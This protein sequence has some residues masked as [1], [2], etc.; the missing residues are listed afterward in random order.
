MGIVNVT[1][2]SFSRDGCF[3]GSKGFRRALALARRHVREGADIIDIGGE[4]TRPGARR[5]PAREE[6]ARVIPPVRALAKSVKVPISVDTY[7]PVVAKAVLDAG[8]GII[9]NIMGSKP[10]SGLL[11]MVRNYNA[12]VVL[13]HIRGTPKTMQTRIHYRDLIADIIGTL[14]K[15]I[16]TCLEIGIGIDKIIIDPGIGFG[17]TV[18]HNLEILN[19]LDEFQAL[20]RPVLI[21]PSRK[22]FIGNVLDRDAGHRLIGTAATVCAGILRG[23]HIVRVH[24]VKAVHE[25]AAMTDAILNARDD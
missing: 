19:R 3:G 21:G 14:R 12:A 22:S 23:A 16:E 9:N 8:A 4:S 25:A 2:D 18:R 20:K 17:K 13:M 6:I 24:D 5:I 11:K 7:K 10:D 15:S 1:P